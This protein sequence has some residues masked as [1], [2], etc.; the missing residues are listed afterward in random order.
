MGG[1][2]NDFRLW[3]QQHVNYPDD[4]ARQGIKG[5][6][7][8]MFVID[9]DG[10]LID[11]KILRGLHPELDKIALDA[12]NSSPKWEPGHLNS[13]D[14]VKVRYSITVKFGDSD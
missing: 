3:V 10:S 8:I 14:P 11:S 7:F 12:V 6:V 5:P 4:L 1:D 2:V 9:K 13:D